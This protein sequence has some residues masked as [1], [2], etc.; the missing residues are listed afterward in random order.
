MKKIIASLLL[1]AIIFSVIYIPAGAADLGEQSGYTAISTAAQFKNIKAGGK[2]YLTNDIDLTAEGVDFKTLSGGNNTASVL[3]IDGCGYTVTTNKPLIDEL[4]GGGTDNHSE[5]RNLKINGSITVSASDVEGYN[6]GMSVGALVGKSNGGIY[7]NIINNASITLS[8]AAEVR[9][10]GIVGAVF[11]ED[12]Y[13]ENCVNNGNVKASVAKTG[14]K[15]GVGGFVAYIGVSGSNEATFIDCVNNGSVE[16][17]STSADGVYAGG[18]FAVKQK[19]DSVINMR[20]CKNNGKI[21]AKTAYGS[22]YAISV[23]QNIN[24]VR[25]TP[26]STAEEFLAISGNGAYKLTADITLN[27]PNTNDFSGVIYGEGYTVTAPSGPFARDNG[28]TVYNLKTN[29][30]CLNVK[31]RPLDSFA[32]VAE[33]ESDEAAKAIFDFVKSKYNITLAIKPLSEN[34]TGN[35]IYVNCGNNYGGVRYGLDYEFTAEGYAHVYL[36]ETDENI[37]NYVNEFLKNK[38][39]TNKTSCD[40]FENFGQKEFNYIFPTDTSQGYRFNEAE[41][42][43]RSLGK[44]VTYIKRTYHTNTVDVYAYIV[45]LEADANAHIEVNA[46]ELTKVESCENGN[47]QNCHLWHGVGVS[48]SGQCAM[49][50]AKGKDVLAATNGG[51]FMR[52]AKC[53]APWG[54]QIVN[55]V[56]DRE[57]STENVYDKWFGITKD[58]K[59]VISDAAGYQSTYKGNILYGLGARY[60]GIQDGKYKKYSSTSYDART[61]VG[62]NAKGD[63]VLVVVSG[64][65][66]NAQELGATYSNMAQIFMDL[67]IDVTEMLNLDGGGS[68]TMVVDNA[69]GAYKLESALLS[70]TSER[71]LGNVLAVVAG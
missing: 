31:G 23:Y 4:P 9:V 65:D 59:P 11:N 16:N 56:V 57:P 29:V 38:L 48:T 5:I 26:V 20:D 66:T 22:Y 39:T 36:D 7:K 32:I 42:V 1:L 58:G 21:Y 40:F 51:F 27:T 62:Y 50:E 41:D 63:I 69:N 15:H 64:D 6:N 70:G 30:T 46:T 60:I 17:I 44:G 67:D 25:T 37:L 28:I 55:G 35:A 19:A 61:A 10:G 13:F 8:D 54:M 71:A 12:V 49:I 14:D 3:I 18:I 43:T 68:S 34:Y 45:V 47:E 53:M 2:Y 33:S 52:S 24:F